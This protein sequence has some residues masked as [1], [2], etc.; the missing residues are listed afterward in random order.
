MDEGRSC[1]IHQAN[2]LRIL[3]Y[4]DGELSMIED[5]THGDLNNRITSI[6]YYIKDKVS[7]FKKNDQ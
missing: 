6:R 4:I 1:G 5:A 7:E 2:A 3:G